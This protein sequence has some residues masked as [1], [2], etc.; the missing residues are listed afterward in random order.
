[1]TAKLRLVFSITILF[2]SFCGFSQNNYWQLENSNTTSLSKSIQHLDT[3]KTKV[4][5]LEH[6]NFNSQ[7][8]QIPNNQN[9]STLVY[10]PN[11]QGTLT[12]FRVK[13]KQLFAPELAAKYPNIKSYTGHAIAN[14][15]ERI[16]FS[17]SHNGI[18]SMIIHP[19]TEK[20]TFMQKVAKNSNEYIVY[21]Q[22]AKNAKS[23]FVC[24][25]KSEI[26][27]AVHASTLKLVDDQTLR[28]YRVAISASGEYTQYHGGTKADALA[29][30][31]ATITR[32]NEVFEIDLGVTLEL[33]ANNDEIIYTDVA[34]D[35]YNGNFNTEAQ[36]TINTTIGAE[37]YDVGHLFTQGSNG[38]NAGFIASVCV[39]TRKAS[40]YS[41]AS[42]PEGDI[43]D[44]DFVSHEMGHQFG[45]NH[46]WSFESEGTQVQAEP[47]SG[48]TIMGYAGI[49]DENNV[50][51]NGDDY[52]HYYSIFQI[53]EYLK[54]I[55][56]GE[57]TVMTN[58]PP[59]INALENYIIPKSTPFVLTGSASDPDGS[60][61][62]TYTWEQIDDGVVTRTSFGPNNPG[63][64]NFRSLK[65]T[66]N[67]ERYF[68]RLSEIVQGN[69]T[70]ENPVTG[71]TWE[72]LSDVER[73]MNFALTVRDNVVGGGQVASAFTTVS[74][75]NNAGPF[76]VNSQKN[77]EVYDAGTEQEIV[78]NVA[79]TNIT[80]INA[81]FVDIYL[82]TDGGTTFP[83]TLAQNV[84]NDGSHTILLPGV[85]T[86][87][88]RIMVKAN[89]NIFFAI[90]DADFEINA[91]EIVLNFDQL[92]Y[93]VCQPN[94]LDIPFMYETFLGFNETAT[95]SVSNAPANLVS[96]FSPISATVNSA[97][98]LELSN[99]TNVTPGLY[100]I[101]VTATA[102]SSTKSVIINVLVND[103]IYT[104][105]LL[106]LPTDG[107]VGASLYQSLQWQGNDLYT[108]Y[109]IEVATDEAFTTIIEST[110]TAFNTFVPSNLID[111]T[112]YYWRVKPKN[113]CGEGTFGTPY[114]FTTSAVSCDTNTS[115]GLP[116]EISSIG[117]PTIESK[118]TFLDDLP[119]TDVN[120]QL[121][122]AH[123]Y[124]SDLTISLTSPEG[125][126]VVL[127]A[128]SCGDA[129]D[130][131]A[132]FDDDGAVFACGNNPAINGAVQPLGSLSSFNGESL[133][134]EWILKI[135][136][137]AASDGGELIDFS[138]EICAEGTF[139]IDDDD[140]G[141]FDD[142]DDLCLGTPKGVEVNTDGCPIYR[143]PATQFST[144]I[145][146]E[147][148]RTNNDGSIQITPAETL[149]YTINIT[150]NGTNINESFTDDYTASNLMA[151]SY[152][153]C[154]TGTDGIITYEPYCFD[155]LITEPDVLSIVSEISP[156]GKKVNLSLSGS[157]SY[158]IALNG[159]F[160]QTEASSYTINLKKG[161][162]TLKVFTN[163]AC[164][165]IHEEQFFISDKAII[166]PNPVEN[167]TEIFLGSETGR[168]NLVLFSVSG[169]LIFNRDMEIQNGKI[170]LDLSHLSSGVYSIQ[171]NGTQFK[172]SY[173][174]I[175]E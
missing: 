65:P 129:Q 78:W 14:P 121:D 35:P 157:D 87:T 27:K 144:A 63:G 113:S 96:T 40:A 95:F 81:Q 55:S 114:S 138:L 74:V 51:D 60:D 137:N 16:R 24:E 70:Q 164:Q 116:I 75:I 64:A 25:T 9:G 56:C 106:T 134:G 107:I 49:V 143:F 118:V 109:D 136:D 132:T 10:F 175:K 30:I 149:D 15:E 19:D 59:V 158:T 127:I 94:T 130:I 20:T 76:I 104:N 124:V 79:K 34:T 166:S 169:K 151:G 13:E 117:T 142:G 37:N 139:R 111:E 11:K 45:A 61:I 33:I 161:V 110:T 28:K 93:E 105:P 92:N 154:I 150:G 6:S 100:P 38:G 44:L 82:S 18:Q 7:L 26:E 86:T 165:G 47:A 163:L 68:P 48:T 162:N 50:A 120:V 123:S 83:I 4:F 125:T 128:S 46:T 84:L 119:I 168:V 108:S 1:M 126:T 17:V 29:A 80:P 140:D 101:T 91:S 153:V 159:I 171:L 89:D 22:S 57:Q 39:D 66:T 170:E 5:T 131:T 72:T 42:D 160:I 23:N 67:P 145:N 103:A 99:T 52:F 98:N 102:A 90:N 12:A 54:T 73:D 174:I 135:E 71:A 3:K 146:S 8:S 31:N 152:T 156:D 172:G 122:I 21:D 41:S 88:A 69:L 141:V 43:F 53:T 2:V 97:I 32:V 148:C 77:G 36:N 85:D 112:T 62:L 115:N 147:S 173:K 58:N 155:A 133:L 167:R